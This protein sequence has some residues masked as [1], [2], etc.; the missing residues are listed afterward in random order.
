MK[1]RY[2]IVISLSEDDN[3][4]LQQLREDGYQIVDIFRLGLTEAEDAV[5]K[6]GLRRREKTEK[7]KPEQDK[8]F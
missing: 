1:P 2:Q 5:K 7:D 8:L 6:A 4:K 3:V